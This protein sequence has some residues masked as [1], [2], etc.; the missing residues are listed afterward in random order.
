VLAIVTNSLQLEDMSRK[1]RHTSDFVISFGKHSG[2]TLDQI[3][4]VDN[5]YIL[6]LDREGILKVEKEFLDACKEDEYQREL[7]SMTEWDFKY[8]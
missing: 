3:A 1:K 2:K 4:E 5:S 6:W 8:M 7:N